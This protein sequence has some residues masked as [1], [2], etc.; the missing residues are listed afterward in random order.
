[1]KASSRGRAV[2]PAER[3]RYLAEISETVRDYHRHIG[4]QARAARERQ[5]L[6]TVR[7]LFERS[8]KPVGGIR[9]A[10]SRRK[11]RELDPASAKLLEQWPKTRELYAADE[12]VVKI[13]DKE[14]RTKLNHESLSG[15]K[16]RKV[17]LPRFEDD[18]EVLR[19]LMKENRARLVPVHRRR[20]RVQARGRGSDAHVRRRGRCVPDQSALQARFGRHAG[21]PAVHGVRFG[22]AV[23]VGSRSA[24]G[25]LRQGRQLR[26]LDRDP[27]RHEGALF[28]FR[29][30]R[31][32][33]LR[34]HDHQ[35]ARADPPGHVHEHGHRSAGRQIPRAERPRRHG[36]RAPED[37]GLDARRPCAARFRPT[38]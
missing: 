9:R 35:R 19:F 6:E 22:D 21:A 11:E 30:V 38:S 18:G 23:R 12:Y 4:A 32:L 5:S 36:G 13:R 29:P 37:Q 20:V 26:R 16:V 25:H 1:M 27:R 31:A 2:V 15:T 34:V 8:G 24:A 3:V 28:G 14:I 33:D 7:T 17:S 10:R